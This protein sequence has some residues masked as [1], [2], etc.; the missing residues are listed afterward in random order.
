MHSS[1]LWKSL[2][3]CGLNPVI[4]FLPLATFAVALSSLVG[5]AT[6][7]AQQAAVQTV[8]T[9]ATLSPMAQGLKKDM[10]YLAS[11]ALKGRSAIDPSIFQ[12]RDYLVKRMSDIGLQMDSVNG[13]PLQPVTIATPSRIDDPTKNTCQLTV[14]DTVV[15]L[16]VGEGFTP[17]IL[18]APKQKVTGPLAFVGYGV[19]ADDPQY[20]DYEG[21]DVKGAIVMMIRK[22]PGPNDADSPFDG[23]K[24]TS[25]AFFASKV[26][27]A[28]DHGAAAVILVN[29]QAS[30]DQLINVQERRISQEQGRIA[31]LEK[32]LAA[33]DVENPDGKQRQLKRSQQMLKSLESGIEA[34]RRGVLAIDA[35]GSP[36]GESG[37]VPVISVA[38]DLVSDLLKAAGQ[39]SVAEL[40][41][42]I[43]STYKPSSVMLADSKATVSVDLTNPSFTS[44]NVIGR[45][46]GKGE[47]A[48]EI[49]VVGAH[50]DHVGMGGTGSL[51]PGTIAVHN[52]ADDNASGTVTMLG[53]ATN[54]TERLQDVE[55]HRTVLFIGFTGEERGL[56]GSKH[57]VKNPVLPIEKTSSMLNLDMVG[58][59]KDNELYVYG[60][61]TSPSWK[62]LI[63]RA[64]EDFGFKLVEESGGYGPSD[65]DSFTRSSV[66]VL[67]YFTGLHNDYH[68]PS[69]D[70]D[71]IDFGDLAR[72]TD[73]VSTA[74]FEMV[75]MPQRPSFAQ[76]PKG[77]QI[78][79]QRMVYL[80]VQ[81]SSDAPPVTVVS[82]LPGS[83]AAKAGIAKGDQ[84]QKI[85]K[86]VIKTNEDLQ[87][88][89]RARSPQE[90][91]EITVLRE[92][93]QQRISGKLEKR[94]D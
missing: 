75:T 62:G 81:L 20:D 11:D 45:L 72:I 61:G 1:V 31:G 40:E 57:Y 6:A 18:G 73:M 76:T 17:L 27:N 32:A 9:E 12:A 51:A 21:L 69:D 64:N 74:A 56:L 54:L 50:Y 30:I 66:P 8:A 92:G 58:R 91:F 29:D 55:S 63:Q 53:T 3:R 80:G 82:V 79:K 44:E 22:E 67:F 83:P 36:D 60:V 84:L 71:K 10:E 38:R 70:F 42:Q 77:V 89:V 15:E 19:T 34:S 85:G 86:T 48:D 65:H 16:G 88:W 43:N 41:S 23:K 35:A 28:I 59:L 52:G 5:S 13:T 2:C 14:G 33:A 7:F 49:V 26:K 39:K 93:Q 87:S 90:S 25:H 24:N 47:L 78:R 46:P 68:R 37:A 4:A 94:P